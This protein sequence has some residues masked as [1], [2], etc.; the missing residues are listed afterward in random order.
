MRFL[1]VSL[2]IQACYQYQIL[3][4]L[5]KYFM[6]WKGPLWLMGWTLGTESLGTHKVSVP[7]QQPTQ[8]HSHSR[9]TADGAGEKPLAQTWLTGIQQP[10]TESDSQE[11]NPSA[12]RPHIPCAL[13]GKLECDKCQFFGGLQHA[14]EHR[15]QPGQPFPA[16]FRA[17]GQE[18]SELCRV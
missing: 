3:S 16:L 4:T 12:A 1:G 5:F 14:D 2:G 13:Q 11:Q 17:V 9:G 15:S 18:P 7:V 10:E 8:E 6:V